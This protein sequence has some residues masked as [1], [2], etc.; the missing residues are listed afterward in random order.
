[1]KVTC[2]LGEGFKETTAKLYMSVGFQ[3]VLLWKQKEGPTPFKPMIPGEEFAYEFDL[4]TPLSWIDDIYFEVD[5][6]EYRNSEFSIQKCT[7]LDENG[8]G[9]ERERTVC[10][11]GTKGRMV[12]LDVQS[13]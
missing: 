10:S 7:F 11:N 12:E 4:E 5:T 2:Q 9:E 1:M 13:C 3:N 8:Q 6:W